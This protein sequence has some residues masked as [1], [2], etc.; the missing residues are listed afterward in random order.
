MQ[1]LKQNLNK[2]K[3]QKASRKVFTKPP[4]QKSRVKSQN[5]ANA[6]HHKKQNKIYKIKSQIRA[7]NKI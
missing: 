2:Q 1:T 6:K 3:Y 4:H 7:Q 5:P